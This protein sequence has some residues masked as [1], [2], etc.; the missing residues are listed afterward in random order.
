MSSTMDID[1]DN[2]GPGSLAVDGNADGDFGAKSCTHTAKEVRPWWSVDLVSPS[3]VFEVEITNRIDCCSG[4]TQ[5]MVT[6]LIC[7]C[8]DLAE[9]DPESN[10]QT[11]HNC[12]GFV[13][14]RAIYVCQL[15]SLRKTGMIM[16]FAKKYG[17]HKETCIMLASCSRT[18]RLHD[19]I[20][21]LTNTLPTPATGPYNLAHQVCY[22]Y[23]GFFPPATVTVRCA[24]NARGRY[25]FIQLIGDTPD[26]YLTLCEVKVYAT[27]K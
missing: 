20:V 7:K 3:T 21:G 8:N 11:S 14:F 4:T 23:I 15:N 18:D 6:E 16:T 5:L 1:N 10:D 24:P 26:I 17:T 2:Y 9:Y 25:L 12:S 19:F 22:Y 27:G 13:G